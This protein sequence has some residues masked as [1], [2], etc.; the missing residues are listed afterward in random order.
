MRGLMRSLA[1]VG[2]RP[3]LMAGIVLML[4]WVAAYRQFSPMSRELFPASRSG[5]RALALYLTGRY[6]DAARA[7]RD[8]Q[9]GRLW[10]TYDVD[11]SGTAALMAGDLMEAERRAATT[12]T[13]VP[14][15]IEPTVTLAE[16]HLEAKQWQ[17][18]LARLEL[19][20][21]REPDH[22][23]A[24]ILSVVALARLERAGEAIQALNRA[25]RHNTP[26][27]RPTLLFR[28][29]ELA[30]DLAERP[31]RERPLCLLAHLHRYLRI[32]D[33]RHAGLA[34]AYAQQAIAAEDRPAD[35]YLA[36]GIIYDKLGRH[37]EALAALQRAIAADPQHAEAYRWA[38]FEADKRDD[39]VLEYRMARAAF[40]AA[41]RDPFYLRPLQAILVDRLGDP[42]TFATLLQQAVDADPRNAEAHRRLAVVAM[43]LGQPDRAALHTRAAADAAREPPR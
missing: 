31:A 12:L 25:L 7:Y 20:R 13:L 33:D 28:V 3:G 10:Y 8:A 1:R 26:G 36:L 17:S 14:T 39:L 40:E 6:G 24:L 15:A 16:L 34:I 35:A 5:V 27:T 38:A 23:D 18:G 41:P 22:V 43:T 4:I 11:I 2:V 29:M 9:R 32:F 19:I 42:H 30:G 21:A 37:H